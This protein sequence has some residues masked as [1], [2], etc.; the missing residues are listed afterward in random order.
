MRERQTEQVNSQRFTLRCGRGR[1]GVARIVPLGRSSIADRRRPS[2]T[3]TVAGVTELVSELDEIES[4]PPS[5]APE[6]AFH[7]C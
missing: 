5:G 3:R 4:F 6:E 1:F 2:A 7:G